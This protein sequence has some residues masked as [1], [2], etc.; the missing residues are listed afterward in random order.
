MLPYRLALKRACGHSLIEITV[1]Y[2][3]GSHLSWN[4][5]QVCA[6]SFTNTAKQ[7]MRKND[8]PHFANEGIQV[9]WQRL[10][11]GA[12]VPMSPSVPFSLKPLKLLSIPSQSWGLTC[13]FLDF[14]SKG[15]LCTE[16]RADKAQMVNVACIQKGSQGEPERNTIRVPARGMTTY[17]LGASEQLEPEARKRWVSPGISWYKNLDGAEKFGALAAHTYSV[18]SQIPGQL[19]H[20]RRHSSQPLS[21]RSHFLSLKAHTP[22]YGT[23]RCFIIDRNPIV[24]AQGRFTY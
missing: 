19:G 21:G 18:M 5:S 9:T 6:T 24:N 8:C 13:T 10:G 22:S 1:Q 20:P 14:F 2:S 7:S 16:C 11:V 23:L 17:N 12:E 15:V 4:M 3:D